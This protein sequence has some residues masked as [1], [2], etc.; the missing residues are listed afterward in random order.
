MQ[1]N[2]RLQN[3][4][5]VLQDSNGNAIVDPASQAELISECFSTAHRH[6][7]GF[8]SPPFYK[9]S[10]PLEAV[11]VSSDVVETILRSLDEHKSSGPDKLHP[12]ILKILAPFIAKPLAHLF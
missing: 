8:H 7:N 2:K 6:D 3:R 12:K 9:E 10:I 1:S 5:S 4:I 11:Q